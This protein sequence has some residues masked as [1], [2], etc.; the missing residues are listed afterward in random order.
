VTPRTLAA[1]LALSA[2]C[3]LPARAAESEIANR[4]M[5]ITP[6]TAEKAKAA[7][8]GKGQEL[9]KAE[10]VREEITVYGEAPEDYRKPQKTPINAFSD[11]LDRS[12]NLTPAQKAQM[13]LS[14]F[15]GGP[16]PEKEPSA[17]AR[18]LSRSENG[19]TMMEKQRGTLQ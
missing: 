5:G 11:R 7:Q 2:A 3:A 18:T 1:L 16:M 4:N 10:P 6:K 19:G 17:E 8:D 13:V 12:R 15:L 14:F 9:R